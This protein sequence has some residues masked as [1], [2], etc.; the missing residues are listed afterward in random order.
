[1]LVLA[2]AATAP[3]AVAQERPPPPPY[4]YVGTV[5]R[6]SER[7]AVLTARDQSVLLVRA[8]ETINNEYRVA[9]I[10]GERLR[11]V[12]LA[13]GMVQELVLALPG[14]SG[15]QAPPPEPPREPSGEQV[16]TR[17]SAPPVEGARPG[18]EH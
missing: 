1:L 4:A 8:G 17:S 14:S 18:Y 16:D 2:F 10:A 11:L 12:N 9:S 3:Q 7:F 13:S 15:V 5:D 6:G